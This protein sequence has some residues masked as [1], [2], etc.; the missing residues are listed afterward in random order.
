MEGDTSRRGAAAEPEK[1]VTLVWWFGGLV[2]F[3]GVWWF[4]DFVGDV[5][6]FGDVW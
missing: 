4:G 3:G 5:W 1:K 2:M 6:W